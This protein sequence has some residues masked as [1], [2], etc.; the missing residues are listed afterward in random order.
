VFKDSYVAKARVLEYLVLHLFMYSSFTII[1]CLRSWSS[2]LNFNNPVS[3]RSRQAPTR[4]MERNSIVHDYSLSSIRS[5]IIATK[6][7]W[8]LLNAV[9]V[10]LQIADITNFID[11][12]ET[13]LVDVLLWMPTI[14]GQATFVR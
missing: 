1:W 3:W 8:C 13:K 4:Q 6:Y 7:S 12:F 9:F 10:A 11:L 2:L 14:A 5:S